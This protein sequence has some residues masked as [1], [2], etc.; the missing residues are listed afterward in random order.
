MPYFNEPGYE[1]QIGTELGLARSIDYNNKIYPNT[2]KLAMIDMIKNPPKGFEN[3]IS[4]HFK[5]KKNDIINTVTKWK[6]FNNNIN[7]NELI[8]LLN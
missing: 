4:N 1:R 5:F 7:L 8:E 6:E 3:I 2:V